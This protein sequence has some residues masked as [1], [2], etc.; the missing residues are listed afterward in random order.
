LA[1][2]EVITEAAVPPFSSSNWPRDT[3]T[4]FRDGAGEPI[5]RLWEIASL[6]KEHGIPVR[7]LRSANP[8]KVLYQ[9]SC[10]IVV[11]EWKKL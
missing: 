10:Q 1:G 5:K 8:G 9:D 11:E 4:W 3:V 7:M 2:F 6:L